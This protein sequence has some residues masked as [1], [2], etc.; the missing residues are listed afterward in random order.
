MPA[1]AA[2]AT[3]DA[4]DATTAAE[5]LPLFEGLLLCCTI[6]TPPFLFTLEGEETEALFPLTEEDAEDADAGTCEDQP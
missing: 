4:A 6:T 2:A 5:L 1:D 3:A